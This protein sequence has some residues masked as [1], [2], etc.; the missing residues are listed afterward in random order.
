M[1]NKCICIKIPREYQ[2]YKFKIGEV[3]FYLELKKVN[4]KKNLIIENSSF[5]ISAPFYWLYL[6][7]VPIEKFR[8]SLIEKIID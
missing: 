6:Y 3:F 1:S 7:F 2:E 8:N 4:P 5:T